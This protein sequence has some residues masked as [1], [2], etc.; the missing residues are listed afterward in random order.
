MND[1]AILGRAK[2]LFF[3]HEPQPA[4]DAL[5]RSDLQNP[6]VV[7]T[8]ADAGQRIAISSMWLKTI[9]EMDEGTV[10]ALATGAGHG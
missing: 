9:E 8:K 2:A 4:R 10:I 1:E 3:P 5:A 7:L 6:L